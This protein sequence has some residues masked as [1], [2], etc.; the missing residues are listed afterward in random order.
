MMITSIEV[1][2]Y[3]Y[4]RMSASISDGTDFE[5]EGGKRKRISSDQANDSDTEEEPQ[6]TP[7]PSPNQYDLVEGNTKK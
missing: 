5:S 2:I 4:F 7:P 6:L 1:K 3:Y